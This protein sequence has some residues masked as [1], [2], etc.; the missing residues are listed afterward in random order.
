MMFGHMLKGCAGVARPL[1]VLLIAFAW[2]VPSVGAEPGLYG[3]AWH[4]VE[5]GGSAVTGK[6]PL[7]LR[8]EP[9]G[10]VT[11][12]GGCNWFNGSVTIDGNGMTF[13]PFAATQKMCPP[14]VMVPEQEFLGALAAVATYRLDG[15]YL[16][17]DDTYGQQRVKLTRS[18]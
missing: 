15:P 13:P 14:P 12:S 17:L 9:D 4:A 11:G 1:G 6:A 10:K 8:F 3:R 16:I 2:S 7:T 18:R 5:I